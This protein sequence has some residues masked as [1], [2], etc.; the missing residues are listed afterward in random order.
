[1]KLAVTDARAVPR[2]EFPQAYGP[3]G[4]TGQ[5]KAERLEKV[6]LALGIGPG[7]EVQLR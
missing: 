4:T 3:K 5:E 7:E 2:T 6:G 1:M